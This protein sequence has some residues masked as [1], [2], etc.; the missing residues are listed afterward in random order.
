LSYCFS[1]LMGYV[2]G[3]I[4]PAYM[5]G[6]KKGVDVKKNGSGNA[7]ASNIVILFG[8]KAGLIVALLDIFKAFFAT[9]LAKVLFPGIAYAEIVSGSACI[10]GHMF[11]VEMRFK[12][13]KGFACLGGMLLALSARL[14][15]L[16][17]LLTLA[18]AFITNYVFMAAMFA[19]VAVPVSYAILVRDWIPLF[20]MLI[21]TAA[22][23]FRPRENLQR[24][25]AGY[26][27]EF[28]A[29]WQR[30]KYLMPA[31]RKTGVSPDES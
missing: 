15:V 30:E 23:C 4:N 5:L 6:R 18:V 1:A 26:E 10:L 29:L 25:R 3:C 11:P 20:I 14:F 27:A 8:N 21:I 24:F 22:I 2:L 28:S 16:L 31:E 19:A 12:G 7:G 13:G 9:T 17:L